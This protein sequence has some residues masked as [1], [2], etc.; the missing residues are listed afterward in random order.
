MKIAEAL[1]MYGVRYTLL[2]NYVFFSVPNE[3]ILKYSSIIVLAR[4]LAIAISAW[5]YIGP[6]NGITIAQYKDAFYSRFIFKV[7]I[8]LLLLLAH[9]TLDYV[10]TLIKVGLMIG[11][12]ILFFVAMKRPS[13]RALIA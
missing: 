1:T 11:V 2:I 9:L 12:M 7:D 4:M 6:Y 8:G 13:L 5:C 10:G 3:T